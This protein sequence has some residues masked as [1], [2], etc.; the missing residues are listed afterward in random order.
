MPKLTDR[1]STENIKKSVL[2]LAAKL[3][4]LNIINPETDA[5]RKFKDSERLCKPLNEKLLSSDNHLDGVASRQKPA[6]T[7]I[8]KENERRAER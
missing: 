1:V 2:Q 8:Q 5:A 3:G 7:E 4:G 6:S